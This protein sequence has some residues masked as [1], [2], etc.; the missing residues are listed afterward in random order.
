LACLATLSVLWIVPFTVPGG[1]PVMEV[2][3]WSPRLPLI[4]DGPVL[5][6]VEPANT[7]KLAVVPRV[8]GASAAAAGRTPAMRTTR[9]TVSGMVTARAQRR[10]MRR[11]SP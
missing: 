3:G 6:T 9:A 11:R 7:A 1:K 5:V 8:T 10:R 2:P 4:V